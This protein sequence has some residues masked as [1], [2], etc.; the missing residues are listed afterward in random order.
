MTQ[1]KSLH[2]VSAVL[3][4]VAVLSVM[5]SGFAAALPAHA[6]GADG[7]SGG[8]MVQPTSGNSLNI[9]LEPDWS[10]DTTRFKVSFLE[11][12][13][14]SSLHQHQD[15]DFVILQDGREVFS[16]A[17]QV[18]QQLIHNVEGTITVPYKFAE[19]GSYTVEVRIYGVGLPAIP[20]DEKASFNIQV[21][22]E[23]P[24]AAAMAA[25]ALAAAMA[26][27]AGLAAKRLR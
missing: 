13:S 10:S 22:P 8:A 6:Q 21:T 27:S 26:A 5:A 7:G 25:V 20:T 1:P 2:T 9:K 18:N 15:Y 11:P 3:A 23:F 4:T 14:T 24:T 19:N 12:G 16:A 17:K